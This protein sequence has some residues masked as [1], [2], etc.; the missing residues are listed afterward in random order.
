M[1]TSDTARKPDPITIKKYANR[2]LYNTA[3]STYVTLDAL[4][5]MIREGVEFNVYD[6]KT[7][8]DLTRSVLVQIIMEAESNGRS[9]LPISFMRQLIG[10][11][12]GNMETVLSRYLDQSMQTFSQNK[13]KVRDMLK[14]VTGGIFP[15][16]ALEELGKQNLAIFERTMKMF[17]PF[18][19]GDGGGGTT[20]SSSPSPKAET[21]AQAA[22]K[23]MREGTERSLED[24]QAQLNRL[25][26]QIGSIIGKK[27]G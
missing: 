7:G 27:R 25:Q 15:V 13:D 4:A 10:F 12:G 22:V 24:L 5:R 16:A 8:E 3:T 19:V 11:Y 1:P 17:S 23:R 6:A 2:R 26:D 14:T 21:G 20:S 9:M 18:G